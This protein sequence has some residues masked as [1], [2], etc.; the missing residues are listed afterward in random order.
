MSGNGIKPNPI[1]KLTKKLE[2][3]LY[4]ATIYAK[5]T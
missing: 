1:A 4:I 5:T 3:R 2:S